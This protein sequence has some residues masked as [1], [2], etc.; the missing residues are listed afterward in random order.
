MSSRWILAALL[1]A[2]ATANAQSGNPVDLYGDPLPHG[3][4]ARLGTIRL[5]HPRSD[6]E[7]VLSPDGKLLATAG[8]DLWDAA[9]G[10]RIAQLP[11]QTSPLRFSPDGRQLATCTDRGPIHLWNV[12]DRRLLR[13]IGGGKYVTSLEFSAAGDRLLTVG[14]SGVVSVWELRRGDTKL[15]L[16][17]ATSCRQAVFAP[18]GKSLVCWSGS[19]LQFLDAETG[20]EQQ[21]LKL[22]R[23]AFES[24]TLSPDGQLLI[25][26]DVEG[27][28]RWW[29]AATGR[30]V[31]EQEKAHLER[32]TALAFS[33]DGKTLLSAGFDRTLRFWDAA[34]RRPVRKLD[35][36]GEP[37]S[38]LYSPD[39]RRIVLHGRSEMAGR[40]INAETG[41]DEPPLIGH[42]HRITAMK[43]SPN[44]KLLATGTYGEDKL[45]LWDLA[46]SRQ[47]FEVDAGAD[48]IEFTPNGTHAVAYSRDRLF[49]LNVSSG[50]VHW[51]DT[52]EAGCSSIAISPDG[53]MLFASISQVHRDNDRRATRITKFLRTWDTM[54]WKP[55]KTFDGLEA[56][57][58]AIS[59]DGRYFAGAAYQVE[60][61]S[62]D[63]L[64]KARSIKLWDA[65]TMQELAN[66]PN[67]GERQI[68]SLAFAP[69]GNSLAIAED[70]AP[71][72]V[73]EVPSGK[74]LHVLPRPEPNSGG[75]VRFVSFSPDG[76]VLMA[77]PYRHEFW[78]AA[79]GKH[80]RSI[81]AES[82]FALSP[83]WKR[84][85]TGARDGHVRL[86]DLANGEE[87]VQWQAHDD[88]VR[89]LAFAS[90]GWTV[91]SASN[92]CT[93]LVWDL[94]TKFWESPAAVEKPNSMATLWEK[95]GYP[96]AA[97][98]YE[99]IRMLTEQPESAVAF[100]AEHL[101][102]QPADTQRIGELLAALAD[103]AANVRDDAENELLII[104]SQAKPL[105]REKLAENPPDE[106]RRRV[107]R[108][109][110]E[111]DIPLIHSP[112]DLRH[113][114][115]LQVLERIG[116][117]ESLALLKRVADQPPI[118]AD[119][120]D[121]RD[122]PT[123]DEL[124][125]PLPQF[126][127]ARFGS[128][129]YYHGAEF[130]LVAFS[131]DG[132]LLASAGAGPNGYFRREGA[133]LDPALIIRLWEPASGKPAAD[134]IGHLKPPTAIAFP[135]VADILASGDENGIILWDYEAKRQMRRW[136]AGSQRI[137]V[138]AFS[139]D[140][141]HL[142]SGDQQ[143]A[144]LIWETESGK[145]LKQLANHEDGVRSAVYSGDGKY[146]ASVESRGNVFVWNAATGEQ[147]HKFPTAP[148]SGGCAFTP[149]NKQIAVGFGSRVMFYDLASG[150]QTKSIAV[151]S[152]HA[153]QPRQFTPDGRKLVFVQQNEVYVLDLETGGVLQR[154]KVDVG[155]DCALSPDGKLIAG[156]D[157]GWVRVWDM[158][159]GLSLL[160]RV[161]AAQTSLAVSYFPNGRWLMVRNADSVQFRDPRSGQIRAASPQALTG[162]VYSPDGRLVCGVM[163]VFKSEV[164]V[165]EVASGSLIRKLRVPRASGLAFTT[166]SRHL[167]VAS[168]LGPVSKW[169]IVSGEMVA[170]W[171]GPRLFNAL[172]LSPDGGTIAA[173]GHIQ[174]ELAV[175]DADTG[176][177][178]W[179]RDF[180]FSNSLLLTSYSPTGTELITVNRGL[181]T[182][183][184]DA[185][186]GQQRHRLPV[187]FKLVAASYDGTMLAG[188]SQDG[189][190]R[191]WDVE[192][193]REL[194]RLDSGQ[195][196]LSD[197]R[198]SPDGHRLLT[199]GN[200]R[201]VLLWDVQRA[202]AE[203]KPIKHAQVARRFDFDT[204]ALHQAAYGGKLA[205]VKALLD[206]GAAVN[207]KSF[208]IGAPL[209]MAAVQ[210]HLD[211]CKLLIERFADVTA[212]D[213]H[214]YTPLHR[215]C[216]EGHK[217]V[218]ALLL[219][220]KSGVE[221]K[222]RDGNTPLH[223]AA[224]GGHVDV[225]RLLLA[226]DAPLNAANNV[227]ASPLTLAAQSG[228]L[229]S[230]K[231]LA[232]RAAELD[233]RPLLGR[234]AL[235]T[236]AYHAHP[237][238][239][240]YLLDR[241]ARPPVDLGQ[242]PLNDQ[243]R[244]DLDTLARRIVILGEADRKIE[245]VVDTGDVQRLAAYL[246]LQPS[247]VYKRIDGRTLLGQAASAGRADMVKL[248]LARGADLEARNTVTAGRSSYTG[249]ALHLAVLRGH[250]DV[251]QLL[252]EAGARLVHNRPAMEP[253]SLALAVQSD[254]IVLLRY[255]L[256]KSVNPDTPL[257][258]MTP[259]QAAVAK[260]NAEMVKLLLDHKANPN[261]A[262][263][264]WPGSALRQAA[265]MGR[266]DLLALL[267]DAG[268]DPKLPGD[269]GLNAM[270][271]A[272]M[273]KRIDVVQW[274]AT[275]NLEIDIHSATAVGDL[276]RVTQILDANPAAV[277]ALLPDKRTP[278]HV[279]CETGRLEIAR[280]LLDHNADVNA[281][282]DES[283]TP[284]NKIRGD[285]QGIGKLLRD[286]GGKETPSEERRRLRDEGFRTSLQGPTIRSRGA[287]LFPDG[288]V[289]TSTPTVHQLVKNV[290]GR[291]LTLVE[292]DE[293][294]I[295][296]NV[297]HDP[298]TG[299]EI[300]VVDLT[301][302]MPQPQP[303]NNWDAVKKAS[304]KAAELY[305]KYEVQLEAE[306][307]R[308]AGL[309][310]GTQ[311]GGDLPWPMIGVQ[312]KDVEG[313][314][315]ITLVLPNSPAERAGLRI[316]DM[317]TTIASFRV[318]GF[319]GLVNLIARH[320]IGDQIE[321]KL[322]RGGE[323]LTVPVVIGQ[324]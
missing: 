253:L 212:E 233:A 181:G 216:E 54:S 170:T 69:D 267:L 295:R 29:N 100:L 303:F 180:E 60:I 136:A 15:L 141:K 135:P 163:D 182:T 247:L 43:L 47:L 91:V 42:R 111:L 134:L 16:Q 218:V 222:T 127:V 224:V 281:R 93:A 113:Q 56:S 51:L 52:D 320:Q 202:L 276:D 57:P 240:R 112:V 149:D 63:V 246:Q 286:R 62:G 271:T 90:D 177:K 30:V 318:P 152:H 250:Q 205:E 3:A 245:T 61:V 103:P 97:V 123:V 266:K 172:R 243:E 161:G 188:E 27:T 230:V 70:E 49:A 126:A 179:T 80:L 21:Q 158:Q 46:G 1:L 231:L 183:L 64:T 94:R 290:A 39:G 237:E 53:K 125:D 160:D 19:V 171:Q 55:I 211:I 229:E 7:A 119:N 128:Q 139:A 12:V 280:L 155:S 24:V 323:S 200:D 284:L 147:L 85:V 201:T 17:R 22:E 270:Q 293:D 76:K 35:A 279:A 185:R 77:G 244:Q 210:G 72:R 251:V 208:S 309:W 82:Q 104:G 58:A 258:S 33:P 38:M 217:D 174:N 304:P 256:E 25:S 225:V 122:P 168:E 178:L 107:E 36:I 99:A 193:T 288:E 190:V 254:N 150:D 283:E 319:D 132:Q 66:I 223:L 6:G 10:M 312:G 144:L 67:T 115:A 50:E 88:E 165:W 23:P 106:V 45:R 302:G 130:S 146:M 129:R 203:A 34:T 87:L 300:Q 137:T 102:P 78:D 101:K 310:S 184:W 157:H 296:I 164:G 215:A 118:A 278:L 81:E 198:F 241:G 268:A 176:K 4:A 31:F 145:Q 114:R 236:A 234:S 221:A 142:V 282:D 189:V 14:D 117:A 59:Q 299:F 313:G 32:I 79:T 13:T 195:R 26:G 121:G 285:T 294:G 18:G 37:R 8:A 153:S 154:R 197:L 89:Q 40:I 133:A 308:G 96:Q 207:A 269:Q 317:V 11:G 261:D 138:L 199:F 239:V 131:R 120:Q 316:G 228:N 75:S 83:D 291:R 196:S 159:S 187:E 213:S 65:R 175:V 48:A 68:Y 2:A 194:V 260:G 41:K 226:A 322:L 92:D 148:Y 289:H 227:G 110:T 259:L 105:L 86:W 156:A 169:N 214:Q 235:E 257:E 315:Q 84:M 307:L 73:V 242:P 264:Q 209:H 143:G 5:R 173:G 206:G 297:K 220:S 124:G 238:I 109:L 252:L 204:S 273:A 108:L 265:W 151:E 298:A 249:T 140:G 191:I 44:G 262:K 166:D 20:N 219:T 277:N 314:C 98:A 95:L 321:I 162:D 274:L 306:T 301:Q 116:S 263:D 9:T 292:I 71:V 305:K 248:L 167:S 232:E 275:H 28:L 186:T 74:V 311:M 287:T 272:A 324:R 255:L 192:S